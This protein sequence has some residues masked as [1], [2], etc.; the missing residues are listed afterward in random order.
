VRIGEQGVPDAGAAP[1]ETDSR[2]PRKIRRIGGHPEPAT[3]LPVFDDESVGGGRFSGVVL[4]VLIG[5]VAI[6]VIIAGLIVIT[7]SNNSTS[8]NVAH[9]NN[10]SATGQS[11]H[12]KQTAPPPFN[13]AK[14]TVAVLN[15]TAQSG[16]AGD[17]GKKLGRDGY[18]QG[19]ITNAASQTQSRTFVYF[20]GRGAATSAN[21]TAAHHVATALKLPASRVARAGKV[22]LQSCAISATGSSLGACSAGVV[23]SVGQDRVN[24]ASG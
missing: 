11:L 9:G 5:A 3:V 12:K 22:V 10:S 21:R 20:V 17:V 19:N 6:A 1:V 4:P 18:R 14:V 13:P 15:G 7:N 2:T 8:G 23:V 24:L 16:L